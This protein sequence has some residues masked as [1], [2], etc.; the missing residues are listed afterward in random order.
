MQRGLGPRSSAISAAAADVAFF[1]KQWGGRTS[2][3][4]GNS[5]DG[6]Q[7]RR[8][9]TVR[10]RLI[11]CAGQGSGALRELYRAEPR[12]ARDPDEISARLT[13]CPAATGS[14]R[15][16]T[17]TVSRVPEPMPAADEGRRYM[18]WIS[19]QSRRSPPRRSFV[20]RDPKLCEQ[21]STALQQTPRYELSGIRPVLYAGDFS[22]HV[23]GTPAPSGFS[24]SF[25]AWAC[26]RSS[27][28]ADSKASTWTTSARVL[29]RPFSECLVFLNYDGLP[30]WIGG[31]RAK[32]HGRENLRR[33][34]G[35]EETAAIALACLDAR[36]PSRES[37]L[38]D[39]YLGRA[40]QA[41]YEGRS[42]CCPFA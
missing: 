16:T 13:Q 38:L 27:I 15:F 32:T 28:R 35:S 18:R 10:H 20:E 30:R 17:S 25:G 42:S 33:F 21:L 7:W 12:Q 22:D 26:S 14:T 11:S 29:D 24:P 37:R 2:K 36:Q 39:T 9:P 19:S 6:R 3:A 31:V 8:I 40:A 41:T 5:L 4:G 1:F 34:F 23:D